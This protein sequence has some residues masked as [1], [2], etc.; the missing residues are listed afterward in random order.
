MHGMGIKVV[1]GN[2]Y[3]G[4]II[5]ESDA[6]NIWLAGKVTGWAESVETLTGVSRK[7][8]QS[9]YAGLQKSLHQEWSFVQQVTPSIGNTFGPVEKA[10]RETFVPA[11][12][13]GMGEGAPEQGV[14]HLSVKQA[15][16][17][18]PDPTLTAPENWAPY[19][20]NT[21]HLVASLRG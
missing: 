13:E 3:L 19:C 6:E 9:A 17:A 21:G 12:F 7:H 10:L 2:I 4:W 20:V 11:L 14:T 5:G 1:T 16:L 15:G 18:L 8:P